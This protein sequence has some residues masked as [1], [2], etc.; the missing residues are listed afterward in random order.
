MTSHTPNYT[1]IVAMSTLPTTEAEITPNSKRQRRVSSCP[2]TEESASAA[3]Q[4][5]GTQA[6]G[7]GIAATIAG[8]VM[9]KEKR[10]DS[11]EVG[12][13]SRRLLLT[14][15]SRLVSPQRSE[16]PLAS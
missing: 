14:P 11:V 15:S 2:P 9:K 6:G 3:P 5:E 13:V 4:K 7:E 1:E 8:S 16:R 12:K 10:V